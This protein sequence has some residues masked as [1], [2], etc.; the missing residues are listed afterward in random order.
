MPVV[1]RL[2]ARHQDNQNKLKNLQQQK[3]MQ[4][5]EE[6]SFYPNVGSTSQMHYSFVS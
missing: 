5:M 6:C 4:E 2:M 1:D 3:E